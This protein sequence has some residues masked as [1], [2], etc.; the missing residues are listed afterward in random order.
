MPVATWAKNKYTHPGLVDRQPHQTHK[1]VEA[2][3]EESH[4]QKEQ[5]QKQEHIINEIA[6]I[7]NQTLTQMEM[8]THNARQPPA[9]AMCKKLQPHTD[10]ENSKPTA[11]VTKSKYRQQIIEIHSPFGKERAERMVTVM[12]ARLQDLEHKS[13]GKRKGPDMTSQILQK[14]VNM[15]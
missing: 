6:W 10:S 1:G 15:I 5:L 7:E 3:T 11:K 4:R 2:T 13:S 12:T 9:P 8:D 14:H